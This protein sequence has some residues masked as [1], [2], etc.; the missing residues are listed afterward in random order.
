[1]HLGV[2]FGI[3]AL[4]F[5][6]I[7]YQ[8]LFPCFCVGWSRCTKVTGICAF[9]DQF[10]IRHLM[11]GKEET[12]SI[13][14]MHI[15]AQDL[16]LG[17]ARFRLSAADGHF[18]ESSMQFIFPPAVCIWSKS[19]C[20]ESQFCFKELKSSQWR[21][22]RLVL[23]HAC[24]WLTSFISSVPLCFAVIQKYLYIRYLWTHFSW[25]KHVHAGIILIKG[26]YETVG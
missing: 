22:F 19:T 15:C 9:T 18:G 23:V 12:G 4:N 5:S 25:F 26:F 7:M 3:H 8:V 20:K 21:F 14:T 1:M 24:E 10:M 16:G 6:V 2:W 13:F 17:F 11:G